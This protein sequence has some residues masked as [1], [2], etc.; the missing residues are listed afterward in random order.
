MNSLF[1]LAISSAFAVD[2][3]SDDNVRPA[4]KSLS[5][6][7]T[8]LSRD[9]GPKRLYAARVVWNHVK[10]DLRI[11]ENAREGSMAYDDARLEYVELAA[12]VPDACRIALGYEN[13]VALCAD[14][15]GW[16]EV[17]AAR[18]DL[19]VAL[20]KELRKSVRP[21]IEAALAAI[22]TVQA[23]TDTAPTP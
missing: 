23:P 12:R 1:L 9:D 5:E 4:D 15:L 2:P 22:P 16:M 10:A 6:Y 19:Q 8:D 18:G 21:R 3:T 7:L 20:D 14:M 13:T 11:I 17:T